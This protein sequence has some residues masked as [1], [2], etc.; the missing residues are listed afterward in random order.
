MFSYVASIWQFRLKLVSFLRNALFLWKMSCGIFQLRL[1]I[2]STTS[3]IKFFGTKIEKFDAVLK[4]QPFWITKRLVHLS[5]IK[6]I[7]AT[8]KYGG[9][10]Q[11]HNSK[12]SHEA[13]GFF[14]RKRGR[15]AEQRYE[16][17]LCE[18]QIW[19][20]ALCSFL[21]RLGFKMQRALE[22]TSFLF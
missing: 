12:S 18:I 17:M 19:K 11:V 7:L 13:N 14:G 5:F 20:K 4:M 1:L 21:Y 16:S 15:R 9:R 6:Q 22:S 2:Y 3:Y 10:F 8:A